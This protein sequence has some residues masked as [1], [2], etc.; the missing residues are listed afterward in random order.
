[1]VR[2]NLLVVCLCL[3][4]NR[5]YQ[6]YYFVPLITFWYT[7]MFLT[8][9]LWPRANS[10]NI[11]G[12]LRCVDVVCHWWAWLLPVSFCSRSDS[13]TNHFLMKALKHHYRWVQCFVWVLI[14][15]LNNFSFN[16][17]DV[18][19][20]AANFKRVWYLIVKL[21]ILATLT[22]LLYNFEVSLLYYWF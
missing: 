10:K 15:L 1:M 16:E 22:T 14:Q 11:D 12:E 5:P 18:F 6:F 21:I 7:V 3:V 17:I 20:I 13:Q 4:M 19:I 2:Y 9:A 8:A